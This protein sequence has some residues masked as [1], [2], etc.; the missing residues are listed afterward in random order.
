MFTI[1][2]F[3]GEFNFVTPSTKAVYI[4]VVLHMQQ[5]RKRSAFHFFYFLVHFLVLY[6]RD[7]RYPSVTLCITEIFVTVTVLFRSVTVAAISSLFKTDAVRVI[8]N[9]IATV[10]STSHFKTVRWTIRSRLWNKDFVRSIHRDD[11]IIKRNLAHWQWNLDGIGGI[12]DF[13]HNS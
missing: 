3:K 13:P 12:D 7:M 2:S 4:V 5:W 8:T 9:F 1:S 11:M 10:T 6:N